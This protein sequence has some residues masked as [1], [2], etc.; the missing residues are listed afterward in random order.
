[1]KSRASKWLLAGALVLS[2]FLAAVYLSAPLPTPKVALTIGHSRMM[3]ASNTAVLVT[4]TNAGLTRVAFNDQRWQAIIE[5]RS[6]WVTNQAPFASVA[7]VWLAPSEHENFAVL[8]PDDTVRWQVSVTYDFHRRR[9][10]Y[11]DAW[12]LIQRT[13]FWQQAPEFASDA[14]RWC[15]DLLWRDTDVERVVKTEFFTNLPPAFVSPPK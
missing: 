8:L 3:D 5:T 13:G 4:F 2:A 1:M 7:G 9:D 10:V 6:G 12:A 15:L 11:H 14:A